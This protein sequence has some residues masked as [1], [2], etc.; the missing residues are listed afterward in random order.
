MH[1]GGLSGPAGHIT[2]D[3]IRIAFDAQMVSLA[4]GIAILDL[5]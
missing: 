4:D 3:A 2:G 1:P 5:G